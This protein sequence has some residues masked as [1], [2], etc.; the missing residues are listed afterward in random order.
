[1]KGI[2]QAYVLVAGLVVAST[3]HAVT[4]YTVGA[5]AACTHGTIQAAIDAAI[6]A[7]DFTGTVINIASNQAYVQQAISFHPTSK[8]SLVGGFADCS[9]AQS[10]GS[11]AVIDGAGG[12]TNPVIRITTDPFADVHLSYLTIQH[13]DEDGS[14]K[15]GGIYF[16]GDATL[17]LSHCTVTQNIAGYGGGIYAEADGSNSALTKLQIGADVAVVDNTA[18]Y[19]GG[20]IVNDSTD[21]TMTEPDSYIA[22]NHAQGVLSADGQ[23]I[24]GRGGGLLI[25]DGHR[26][27][28]TKLASSGFGNVATIYLNDAR[29][30][31]GIAILGDADNSA[32][33]DLFSIDPTRP[34][35]VRGNFAREYGGGISLGS[36]SGASASAFLVSQY[37]YIQD[38]A[39][40]HGAAIDVRQTQGVFSVSFNHYAPPSGAVRCPVGV[41]CGGIDGNTAVDEAGQPTGGIVETS[42]PYEYFFNHMTFEGNFGRFVFRG[43]GGQE[44]KAYNV[45]ITGNTTSGSLIA[46]EGDD[47]MFDLQNVTIAGNSIDDSTVLRIG[48]DGEGKLHHSIIWQP[49][50]TTLHLDGDPIDLLDDMVSERESVD[51]GN[52]P[53]VVVQDPRF[54]DPGHGDYSLRAGSPAVDRSLRVAIDG[55]MDLYSNP[56][57]VDL[58][59]TSNFWLSDLGA[60]ERQTLEPLVLNSDFDIDLRLWTAVTEG[61]TTWDPSKNRTGATGS[62]SAHIL[63]PG[64]VT[65]SRVGG[66][67]QCVHLP[68]PAIYALNGWGRGTGTMVTPGDIAELYWEYRKSGGEGCTNGPPDATGTL[69]LSNSPN[70]TRATAPAYINVR[71][72]D[73]TYTSSIAVTL[74]GQEN[75]PSG[76]PTN[77]W[78]DG[79]TLTTETVFTNGFDD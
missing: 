74:V 79:V 30:G 33:L 7:D 34:M 66:V 49:G 47:D 11:H 19:D 6:D 68:G 5:D 58:P 56:R 15:G 65:G 36:A 20:G 46:T 1:M 4:T 70:W 77:A 73:W 51:G 37:V 35:R 45:A 13:G 55:V 60:I 62:G 72:Q 17:E 44:F 29:R 12:A 57:N 38:N 71:E 24:G 69:T 31:G 54:V 76:A 78:F 75:G 39:A 27:V 67:M 52:T 22:N 42:D 28:S 41:P 25:L 64:A 10:D 23:Y 32:Q 14:G 9:Q 26:S 50:K 2:F 8:I 43:D 21:M 40:P 53:Y 59:S 63:Q 16:K 3:S 48:N 18:R 61:V